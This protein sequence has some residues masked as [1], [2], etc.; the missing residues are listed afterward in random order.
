MRVRDHIALSTASAAILAPWLGRDAL[1]VWTGAVLI[2]GDHYVWF[3]MRERRLDP[4]AAVG[5]FNQAHSP[6]HSATRGLHSPL[7][8]LVVLLLGLRRRRFLPL[9]VGMAMHVA[10]DSYHEGRMDRARAAALE[11]D[12]FRC[13]ACGTSG[14]EVGTHLRRQPWLLPSYEPQNLISLCGA[15]HDAAHANGSSPWS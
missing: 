10:L 6:Q 7:A 9:A 15:C 5:F 3:C 2:D 13:Q 4:V 14:A 11:R 1:S 8:L 12:A